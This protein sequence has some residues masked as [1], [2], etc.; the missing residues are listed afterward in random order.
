MPEFGA[1]PADPKPNKRVRVRAGSN[2]KLDAPA[3]ASLEAAP[4]PL[5]SITPTGVQYTSLRDLFPSLFVGKPAPGPIARPQPVKS[6]LAKELAPAY[7]RE[8]K[9]FR[10]SAVGHVKAA[11]P[12]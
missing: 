5:R 1:A 10:C 4:V 6:W 11:C 9:C 7:M 3:P 2:A 8:G 12:Y